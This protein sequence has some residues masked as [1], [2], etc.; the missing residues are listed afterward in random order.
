MRVK[1]S[2]KLSLMSTVMSGTMALVFAI[3]LSL[4]TYVRTEHEIENQL[5][6]QA[7]EIVSEH[8]EVNSGGVRIRETES[9]ESLVTALRR[10]DLSMLIVDLPGN[11]RGKYGIY[12]DLSEQELAVFEPKLGNADKQYR[13]VKRLGG[14]YDTYTLPL[15]SEEKEIGYLQ[16]AR[17][18]NIL[19]LIGSAVLTSFLVMIPLVWILGLMVGRW[20]TRM[21]LLPLEKLVSYVERLDIDRLPEKIII[22][23]DIEEEVAVIGRSFNKLLQRARAAIKKQKEVAENI[24]H[25]LK[26]PLTRVSTALQVMERDPSKIDKAELRE[27]TREIVTLGEQVDALLDFASNKVETSSTWELAP[28]VKELRSLIPNEI[29]LTVRVPDSMQITGQQPQLRIVMNNLVTNA[30]R[31]NV[32]GGYIRIVAHETKLGW[33]IEVE[34]TT[35]T[36]VQPRHALAR[37]WRGRH[38][39]GHG[40][41]LTIAQEICDKLGILLKYENPEPGLVRVS[42]M[43]QG[44]NVEA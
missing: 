17:L 37:M 26:T 12:R 20:G 29:R 40:L 15:L 21:V 33:K 16:I 9:A 5:A 32:P 19:P 11:A 38:S 14:V 2:T 39:R 28:F 30:V 6:R 8:L 4:A 44:K 35:S 13:D 1:L 7:R 25:E 43:S 31:H 10:Y 24:S 22:P 27:M 34:N 18:N 41:G 3:I 42:L 23:E 36:P